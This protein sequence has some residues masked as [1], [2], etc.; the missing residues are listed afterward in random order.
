M[1][2]HK[3]GEEPAVEEDIRVEPDFIIEEAWYNPLEVINVVSTAMANMGEMD[4]GWGQGK[5][6]NNDFMEMIRLSNKCVLRALRE[7]LGEEDNE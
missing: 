3:E 1:E 4:T 7:E 6:I 2:N 5:E